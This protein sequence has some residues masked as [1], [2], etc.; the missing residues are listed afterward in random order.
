MNVVSRVTTM[1]KSVPV[2][3]GA[4]PFMDNMKEV[5]TTNTTNTTNTTIIITSGSW[6]AV[7]SS[8]PILISPILTITKE[9]EGSSHKVCRV[10]QP[11]R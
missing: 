7:I 4:P 11:S 10:T 9:G 2:L 1:L 3:G 6:M 8:P 5:H